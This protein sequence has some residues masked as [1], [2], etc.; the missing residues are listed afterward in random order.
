MDNASAASR[1]PQRNDPR[2]QVPTTTDQAFR[3]FCHKVGSRSIVSLSPSWLIGHETLT[4]QRIDAFV[5]VLQTNVS[6]Q[7]LDLNLAFCGLYG[8]VQIAA[9]LSQNKATWTNLDLSLRFE[10]SP[11]YVPL[12]LGAV[13]G[14]CVSELSISA[15]L[16][17]PYDDQEADMIS[18][19][20]SSSSFAN[21]L[22][23][24]FVVGDGCDENR[25]D[26]DDDDDDD[27]GG[28]GDNHNSITTTTTHKHYLLRIALKALQRNKLPSSIWFYRRNSSQRQGR[29]QRQRQRQRQQRK[30]G[31]LSPSF[32]LLCTD[33]IDD[34]IRH[35]F[36]LAIK[37]NTEEAA[38]DNEMACGT[39]LQVRNIFLTWGSFLTIER[40]ERVVSWLQQ[41]QQQRQPDDGTSSLTL[42]LKYYYFRAT[43][44][45][46]ETVISMLMQSVPL[47]RCLRLEACGVSKDSVLGGKEAVA[48]FGLPSDYDSDGDSAPCHTEHLDTLILDGVFVTSEGE[49]RFGQ[50]LPH[51]QSLRRLVFSEH[52]VIPRHAGATENIVDGLTQN[53]SICHFECP[54][55]YPARMKTVGAQTAER[56]RAVQAVKEMLLL[57][58]EVCDAIWP[59][60]V[61]NL[62][63]KGLRDAVFELCRN[64]VLLLSSSSSS[65]S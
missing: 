45:T 58:S 39:A 3:S 27:G 49:L 29:Q 13:P 2:G 55:W 11:S 46:L 36:S 63:R 6:L 25:D 43:N 52:A 9:L 38:M 56:N 24:Q 41:Q 16:D 44:S 33:G 53:T 30:N 22:S 1:R 21:K 12:F 59:S 20:F 4:K 62:L 17:Y 48:L 50:S 40:L 51:L 57:D 34:C 31:W 23:F 19:F 60:V 35:R 18:M 8:L 7:R 32:L 47:L 28:G 64:H 10:G 5:G 37:A 65:S 42:H 26:D 54:D 61:Q 14:L 15:P